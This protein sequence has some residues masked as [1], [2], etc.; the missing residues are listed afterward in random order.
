MF[1]Y[2]SH[3]TGKNDLHLA[4]PKQADG[5]QPGRLLTHC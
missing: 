1:A 5:T 3:I 2:L 4:T